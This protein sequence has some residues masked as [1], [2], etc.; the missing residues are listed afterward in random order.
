MSPV[1]PAVLARRLGIGRSAITNAANAG[2]LDRLPSGEI[3]L[4]G[5]S[6]RAYL[7]R[8]T[9]H[10]GKQRSEPAPS[11]PE[12]TAAKLAKARALYGRRLSAL[13]RRKRGLVPAY[14]VEAKTAA[15]REALAE[16][17]RA[18]P[19]RVDLGC[20]GLERHLELVVSAALRAALTRAQGPIPPAPDTEEEPLADELGPLPEEI[21]LVEVK[22]NLDALDAMR[23]GLEHAVEEGEALA[24]EDVRRRFSTLDATALSVVRSWPRRSVAR[25]A[26]ALVAEGEPAAHALLVSMMDDEAARIEQALAALPAERKPT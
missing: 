13:E 19:G 8:F 15:L 16:E 5:A 20:P 3:D 2:K 23:I 21:P 25:L 22:A 1:K 24:R 4:D 26:A 14:I 18:I 6:T 9:L 12:A 10:R 7:A 17:L 11:S